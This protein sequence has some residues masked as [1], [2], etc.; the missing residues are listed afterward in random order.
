MLAEVLADIRVP[1]LGLG[2]SRTTP[3]AVIADRAYTSGVNRTM[4]A[5]RGSRP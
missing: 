3:D 2:R 5:R 1:R 4:L